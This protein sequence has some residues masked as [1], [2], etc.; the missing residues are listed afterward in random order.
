MRRRAAFVLVVA[1]CLDPTQIRPDISTDV[2][3]A[4][5][6]AHQV[7][8]RIGSAESVDGPT[9][10]VISANG[11][12]TGAGAGGSNWVGDLVIVPSGAG[13]SVDLA[14][15][16]GVD[17]DTTACVLDAPVGCIV[18]RRHE[19]YAL[20]REID[21]PI[22]LSRSC[23]SVACPSGQ[24]CKGGRCEDVGGGDA[25]AP[26]AACGD[27]QSDP[28]NCGACG[29]D[30][31]GG[32][33]QN[34]VCSLY[35]G[36]PIEPL[37]QGACLAV[38]PAGVFVT[39]GDFNGIGDVLR[40]P[41][42]GGT[43]AYAVAGAGPSFGIAATAT[44]TYAAFSYAVAPMLQS[45]QS[46][47][48]AHPPYGGAVATDGATVCAAVTSTPGAVECAPGGVVLSPGAGGPVG[49]AMQAGT[50]YATWSDGSIYEVSLGG[51]PVPKRLVTVPSPEGIA[52]ATPGQ[53]VFFASSTTGELDRL[54]E[55]Q[56]IESVFQ[57]GRPHG[58]AFDAARGVLY[59]AD[60]GTSAGAGAIYAVSGGGLS[61][62][63][64]GQ[65]AP[66]C[67]AIDDT[68]V[69]WLDGSTPKKA[70]R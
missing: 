45:G 6:S 69:Y 54:D 55:P 29:F 13:D 24:T 39:T 16:L 15:V 42:N 17:R 23:L 61:T 60:E 48:T 1:A 46:I 34:G 9:A 52:I 37:S 5:V 22:E 53:T 44:E 62:L 32:S 63:A 4:I 27:T 51:V 14:V 66:S 35:P 25:G 26:D 57:L 41:K 47:M 7:A 20:H 40:F 38:S 12:T 67:I 33:C 10:Q 43:P 2:D 3:C 36:A 68:A 70:P 49:L 30:C 59:V 50:L 58:L 65:T 64:A 8:I 18:A 56:I 31:T 19:T 21:V 28:S 11:C